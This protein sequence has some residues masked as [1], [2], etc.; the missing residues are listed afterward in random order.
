MDISKFTDQK[1]GELT[2]ISIP[3]KDWAFVPNPLPPD[4][5]F[6]INLWPLL[7]EAKEE[8][9]RLDGIGRSLPNP[10]LLLRPLQSREAMRS[11][12][13]EGTYAT[14]EELM[15][16]ELQPKEPIS[17]QDPANAFLEVANYSRSLRQ[18]MALLQDLPFCLR[19]I[20]ELHRTLLSGVR[21]KDRTPGEFRKTQNHIGSNFR[22][23]PP[24]PN[25]LDCCLDNSEK[26]LNASV[27]GYDPLV[28][29]YLFHYQ[30]EAIHP[31][32]DG[33]G[34]VGRALLSLMTYRWCGL[35]MPWL[36]MSA[37]FE[38]YKDEYID[39]LFLVSAQ[40]AW[41]TWIEFCLRGTSEQARDAIDRCEKL[42]ELRDVFHQSVENAG[43][44][45]HPIVESLFTVPVLT[46]PG[47][48][49][50]Y[51][52][53]YPT[54]KSDIEKL[55]KLQI[56]KELPNE[57]PKIFYCPKILSVAYREQESVP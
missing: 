11:S 49:K 43:P 33:N 23:I 13:L 41:S 8:I 56:L 40:G 27:T 18:G 14:P 35:T 28:Q 29:C 39:F 45:A 44:R 47:V 46:I 38:K 26:Q 22:F 12:S 51:D 48:A 3:R 36:Y 15:L 55:V 57:R 30:F 1:T 10:E 6:P 31:F 32:L 34:R 17:A 4:W 42:K 52:T 20:K 19:V 5:R 37:Y 9:A 54:A 21:G 50:H 25:Y 7:A 16:F 24:P 53:T 2:Q